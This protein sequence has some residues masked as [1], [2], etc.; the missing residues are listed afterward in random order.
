MTN[1]KGKDLQAIPKLT[2]TKKEESNMLCL[3]I[4]VSFTPP[5]TEVS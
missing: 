1:E 2:H 4:S 5:L 3:V